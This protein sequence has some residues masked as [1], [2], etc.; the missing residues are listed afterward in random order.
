MQISQRLEYKK[1]LLRHLREQEGETVPVIGVMEEEE[2]GE[3][4][5]GEEGGEVMM[6]AADMEDEVKIRYAIF[7]D[8]SRAV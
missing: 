2:E 5:E 7:E 6:K 4:G 3:E 1:L 8:T